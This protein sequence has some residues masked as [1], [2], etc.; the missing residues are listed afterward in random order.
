[1]QKLGNSGL[2]NKALRQLVIYKEKQIRSLPLYYYKHWVGLN[3]YKNKKL[4][5]L[6]DS[7]DN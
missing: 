6:E 4:K 1:M 3:H 2:F 7:I 5:L